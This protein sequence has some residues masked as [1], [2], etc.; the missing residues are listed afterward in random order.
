MSG[1]Q[2]RSIKCWKR[3]TAAGESEPRGL[4]NHGADVGLVACWARQVVPGTRMNHDPE[5]TRR[6]QPNVCHGEIGRP[7][8]HALCTIR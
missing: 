1:S 2:G 6:D 4:C 7:L 3:A 5:G 8:E